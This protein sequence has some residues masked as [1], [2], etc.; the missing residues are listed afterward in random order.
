M[1]KIKTF[2]E[3]RNEA[4]SSGD[5]DKIRAY[6]K[7]YNID[8]PEDEE[9][10]LAGVHKS[11]CNLYIVENSPITLDQFQKSFDWLNDHGFSPS[12]TFDLNDMTEDEEREEG[13]ENVQ[14]T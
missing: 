2:I 11:I 7:K 10:F 12:I 9:I 4:F 8:I 1:L 14:K 5:I 13:E 3:D 6:C